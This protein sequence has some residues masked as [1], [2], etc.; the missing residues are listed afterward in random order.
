MISKRFVKIAGIIILNIILIGFLSRWLMLHVDFNLLMTEATQLN[1]TSIVVS[2]LLGISL[3]IFYGLRMA[4]LLDIKLVPSTQIVI[5]GFGLNACLPFRL[6]DVFKIIF[7]RQFFKVDLTKSS[8]ATVIEKALD[9][10]IICLLALVFIFGNLKYYFAVL[11]GF[12]MLLVLVI[13]LKNNVISNLKNH[14]LKSVL[15]IVQLMLA[16]NKLKAVVFCTVGIWGLTCLIFYLFFN[17]N[18]LPGQNFSFLDAIT[19]LIFTTFSLAIPSMPASIGLFES[20]IVFYLTQHFYFSAEKAVAY[21]L[22]FHLI[23]II[24]QV[25]F[26]ILIL[27]ANLIQTDKLRPAINEI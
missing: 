26:T 18:M 1:Q 24:P 8:F 25:I 3:Y 11:A 6:G 10:S 7:T 5:M 12:L 23:M 22:I 17:Q 19:I 2:V 15:S 27:F 14:L 4:L 9:L 16:K 20:G 21:A 13:F